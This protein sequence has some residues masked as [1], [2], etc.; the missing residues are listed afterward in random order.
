M[1]GARSGHPDRIA[2]SADKWNGPILRH[3]PPRVTGGI[4]RHAAAHCPAGVVA[5][6]LTRWLSA[7]GRVRSACVRWASSLL[8][9]DR[10][11]AA[12]STRNPGC[13]RRRGRE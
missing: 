11:A 3:S 4:Y 12:R 2:R 8:S 1:K 6:R 13:C 7:V 10:C 5:A 9:T